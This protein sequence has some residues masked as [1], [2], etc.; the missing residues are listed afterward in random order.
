MNQSQ[1]VYLSNFMGKGRLFYSHDQERIESYLPTDWPSNH[2]P[3]L[4]ELDNG[5][6]LCTWFAGSDEGCSDV[7]IVMSRLNADSGQWSEPVQISDDVRKAEQN[8]SLFQAPDGSLWLLHTAMETRGCSLEEWQQKLAAGEVEGP[9]AMQNTSQIRC[10]ISRDRGY[11]WE[12][13]FTLFEREG[14]FCRHPIKQLAN[15]EWLFSVWYSLLDG[16]SVFGSDYSVVKRSVDH[17]NTW[18]EE[19]KVPGGKGKVHM[20]MVELAPG[21]LAAF[22]R[23]RSADRIYVSRSEDNGRTWSEAERTEL[24][25]NNASIAATRLQSGHIAII[26]NHF[27]ANNDPEVTLW[28]YERYPVTI[29]ISEDE[30]RTWPY[31]RHVETGD[32]Y[33]GERNTIAN[34][35]FEYPCL[36]QTTDGL[37]HVVYAYRTRECIKHAAFTEQWVRGD[38]ENR[39]PWSNFPAN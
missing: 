35:R 25:N 8:P 3:S 18:S 31:K 30:G 20:S 39:W 34:R 21:R 23:S 32:N 5:D 12:P 14:S 10:R 17:G 38:E 2:A 13:G 11:T 26:F 27:S 33:C 4:V 19:V 1:M 16:Q 22:F 9:F 24:P 28:P 29:A 15:G 7:N 6:L 37:I 36:L